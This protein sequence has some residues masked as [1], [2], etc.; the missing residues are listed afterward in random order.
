MRRTRPRSSSEATQGEPAAVEAQAMPISD[1]T[2]E[3]VALE[4]SDE[5]WELVCGRLRKKPGM[6]VEHEDVVRVLARRLILQLDEH[7]YAVSV[8]GSRLRISTGSYYVPDVCVIP[9]AFVLR[10][11]EDLPRLL[12][13]YEEAMP[14]VVEVW[15]PSTGD[16]DVETKLRE[17]QWRHDLEIWRLHPYERTLIV[18][19]RQPDGFYSETLCRS[20]MVQPATLP[21]VSI[22]LDRLSS[23][24]APAS[25]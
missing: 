1:Q 9:R 20:G 7:E 15:S 11:R 17:Y 19:R 2:Y 13:I 10:K 25:L 23:K 18:W 21:N 5:T 3:R 24:R 4:D 16:Y 12:E 14:L 8:N 22:D 6:T